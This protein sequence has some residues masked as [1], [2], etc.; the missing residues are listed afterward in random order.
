MPSSGNGR[1]SDGTGGVVRSTLPS[2]AT[3]KKRL[4]NT[5]IFF[6]LADLESHRLGRGRN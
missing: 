2:A 1:C 6:P 3:K 4:N 5:K